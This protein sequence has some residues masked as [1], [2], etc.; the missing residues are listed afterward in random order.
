MDIAATIVSLAE[1]WAWIGLATAAPFLL[2]LGRVEPNAR[3]AWIFR[4]MLIPGIVLIW[5]LVLFRWVRLEIGLVRPTARH[6]PPRRGHGLIW[7]ILAIAIPAIL[8][9]GVM[10]RQDRS[11]AWPAPEKIE[12]PAQ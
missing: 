7:L 3:G 5:P 4:P 11:A 9:T 10:V 1:W 12:D 6:E 8:L 2:L